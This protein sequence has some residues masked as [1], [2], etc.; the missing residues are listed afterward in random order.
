M[1][2]YTKKKK[3]WAENFAISEQQSFSL[4]IFEQQVPFFLR[5]LSSKS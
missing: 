5:W 1:F 4:T 2:W 3:S